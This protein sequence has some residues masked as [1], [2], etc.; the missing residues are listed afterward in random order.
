MLMSQAHLSCDSP[1]DSVY[2][3]CMFF[4]SKQMQSVTLSVMKV[5]LIGCHTGS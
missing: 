2:S 4:I 1:Q 5:D 3:K